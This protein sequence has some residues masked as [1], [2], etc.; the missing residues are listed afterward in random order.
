M[1]MGRPGVCCCPVVRFNPVR[2][3]LLGS[4]SFRRPLPLTRRFRLVL[5]LL[6]PTVIFHSTRGVPF[7]VKAPN[8][9]M[10]SARA[11]MTCNNGTHHHHHTL[12]EPVF[13]CRVT[14]QAPE[15]SWKY[16]KVI[17]DQVNIVHRINSG[18]FIVS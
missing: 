18:G 13:R 15:M 7:L 12:L 6:H 14:V 17:T 4:P 1:V 3:S 11:L 10:N 2:S 5:V 8:V 16:G 9:S